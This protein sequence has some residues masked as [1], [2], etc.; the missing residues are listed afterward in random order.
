MI[1]LP[2]EPVAEYVPLITS[3]LQRR[4]VIPVGCADHVFGYL[5]AESMLSEG[6]YEVE[7]FVR[8]FGL[9]GK[10]TKGVENRV[11]RN[12]AEGQ[13]LPDSPH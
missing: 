9:S 7:G 3:L 2:A 1:G 10:F 5:P 6:G 4:I 12:I 13:A 11:V 8:Y